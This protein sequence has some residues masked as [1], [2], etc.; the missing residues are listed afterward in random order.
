MKRTAGPA[1]LLSLIAM[2]A[3]CK[4][5]PKQTA[6][7]SGAPQVLATVV[8]IRTTLQ[9]AN[10]TFT[11]TLLIA[12]GRARHTGELDAWRLFDTKANSVTFV[13]DAAKTIRTEALQSILTTR[14]AAMA[15]AIPPHFPRA[16]AR[17][18]GQRRTIAGV[19]AE[20]LIV[21][22]GA[23]RRELWLGEHRAIPGGLFAMMHASDPPSTPLAPMTRA[24][25]DILTRTRAFPLVDRIELP[26]GDQKL[27][28]ER[29]VVEIGQRDVPA[30]ALAIPSGYRDLTPPRP[31]KP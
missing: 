19:N 4:P 15:S 25:D 27:V 2:Y 21:Q 3:G 13:N 11:H 28:V 23:F 17:R 5:A 10:K 26:Y 20:Q 16:T 7:K 8:T 31:A 14:R 24:A 12:G 1:L 18:T 6:P 22:V 29:S 30:A 9:P